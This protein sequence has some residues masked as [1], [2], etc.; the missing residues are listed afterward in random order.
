ME[1]AGQRVRDGGERNGAGEQQRSGIKKSRARQARGAPS[2]PP[3]QPYLRKQ[4]AALA[5]G[6]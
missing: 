4:L 1:E 3:A 6:G 5:A 2:L